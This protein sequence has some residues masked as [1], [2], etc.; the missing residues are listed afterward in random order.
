MTGDRERLTFLLGAMGADWGGAV[1]VEIPGD[2]HSKGRPRFA[3]RGSGR[4]Q[5]VQTYALD[6]DVAAEARTAS[7]L[8]RAFP[9]RMAGNV[10]MAAIFHRASRQSIDADNLIKHVCDA[11]NGIAW[12]DDSQATAVL[13]IIELDTV[14]PA[15][16]LAFAPHRSS[17]LRGTNAVKM[18]KAC[19]EPFPLE[20]SAIGRLFC[21]TACAANGRRKNFVP[22]GGAS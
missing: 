19:G 2:P 3:V 6:A 11:A 16:V 22:F 10:A 14:N 13:G 8:R 9:E 7:F 20:G 21:G 18:C 17:M 4:R 1:F 15:T 12:V 5:F